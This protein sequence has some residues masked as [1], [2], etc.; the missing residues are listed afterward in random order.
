MD[1]SEFWFD[2]DG[3]VVALILAI[4]IVIVAEAGFRFGRFMHRTRGML[5]DAAFTVVEGGVLGL[6]ALVLGFSF[7]LAESRFDARQQAI[8]TE[9]NAIGT[10]YL[11]AS[12]LEPSNRES[13]RLLL[14][15]HARLRLERYENYA[16][17][18]V[19]DRTAKETAAL[20]RRIWSIVANEADAHPNPIT[21]LLT[22]TTN[23]MFDIGA[24]LDASLANHVPGAIVLLVIIGGL[25]GAGIIGFGYGLSNSAHVTVS[26]LYSLI[27]SLLVTTTLDLDRPSRGFIVLRLTPLRDQLQTMS[28]GGQTALRIPLEQRLH[29]DAAL[30]WE[31]QAPLEAELRLR[32][33]DRL[34]DVGVIIHSKLHG[35]LPEFERL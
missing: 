19:R 25:A 12:F 5:P 14:R 11:R 35:L 17:L 10:T 27:V 9:A 21:S 23:D 13:F 20:Q 16:S 4:S 34:C 2:V 22:Q 33:A 1:L 29:V 18:Q 31:K 26:V 7:S 24:E 6:V 32:R 3:K 30:Y 15:Q 28:A 8:V